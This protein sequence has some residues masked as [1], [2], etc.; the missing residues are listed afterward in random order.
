MVVV[1]RKKDEE[2]RNGRKQRGN[3]KRAVRVVEDFGRDERRDGGGTLDSSG[4]YAQ[5]RLQSRWKVGGN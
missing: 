3:G 5:S 2:R 1:P 4:F